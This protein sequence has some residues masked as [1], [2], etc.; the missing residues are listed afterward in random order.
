MYILLRTST[1]TEAAG[2]RDK[3]NDMDGSNLL[4]G[5]ETGAGDQQLGEVL[6]A[7]LLLLL[8]LVLLLQE[9]G[10]RLLLRGRHMGH[11]GHLSRAGLSVKASLHRQ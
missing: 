3:P 7:V 6:D 10:Q 8:Q 5:H 11:R 2:P 1:L 4:G 9:L